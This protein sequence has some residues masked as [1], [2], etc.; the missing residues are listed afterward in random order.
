[1]TQT[2][3]HVNRIVQELRADGLIELK[4]KVLT[5]LNPR[6]LKEAAQ[7]E[8]SYLH[9]VRTERRDKEVSGGET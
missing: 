5:V 4:N 1:V 7:C 3:V 2:P 8:G 6:K 9:L